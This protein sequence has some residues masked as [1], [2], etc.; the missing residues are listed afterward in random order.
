[1][2]RISARACAFCLVAGCAFFVAA[3]LPATAATVTYYA[4][5]NNSTGAVRI[6]SQSTVCNTG[7]HKIQWNQTGPQGP[8]GPQG[9]KGATGAQGP[10]GA[11]GATGAT[12]PQGPQGLQ[13][14]KGATGATGATGPQ[15][16]QG[17]QG[18]QGPAGLSSGSFEL[19]QADLFPTL[20]DVP[21]VYLIS[22]EAE[23]AS[24]YFVSASLLLYIDANDGA[25]YCFDSLHST[26]TASQYGGSS[27]TGGYQQV[28]ITDAVFLNA[29]DYVQVSCYSENGDGGSFLYNGAITALQINSFFAARYQP[30]ATGQAHPRPLK[31]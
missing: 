14:A 17:L 8:Q 12:G 2:F 11:T 6:V 28:S 29:G 16:P 20:V 26:G 1:M 18:P 23:T 15:G 4:C 31:R 5:I 22:N 25:A 27:L 13:G 24:W 30:P 10:K 21:V 19:L 7:E 9:P 3:Q